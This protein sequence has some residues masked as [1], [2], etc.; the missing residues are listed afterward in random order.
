MIEAEEFFRAINCHEADIILKIERPHQPVLRR[1]EYPERPE[2]SKALELHIKGLLNLAV[3]R[4]VGHNEEVE[5]TRPVIVLWHNGKSR[6]VG[7]LGA[8]DTHSF[9]DRYPKPKIRISLNKESQSV[10]ISPMDS[11]EEFY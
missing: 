6:M 1:P 11:L 9:P 10:Y 8:L 3:R 4:K 7:N 5:I 2:S